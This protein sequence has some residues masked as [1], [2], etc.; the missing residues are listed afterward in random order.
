M[1]KLSASEL[2]LD[3][4]TGTPSNPTSVDT[5]DEIIC[6]CGEDVCEF[7]EDWDPPY[8]LGNAR[9]Q[10]HAAWEDQQLIIEDVKRLMHEKSIDGKLKHTVEHL[11]HM[12]YTSHEA[13]ESAC[14]KWEWDI[15]D[16][17]KK[18]QDPALADYIMCEILHPPPPE[19]L[20]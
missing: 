14:K 17:Q 8:C 15:E 5:N 20:D 4:M 1:E 10:A 6:V 7:L 12:L 11:C 2:W 18:N 3:Y 16:I 19:L 13:L 9:A